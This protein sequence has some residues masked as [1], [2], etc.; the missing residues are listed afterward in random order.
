MEQRIIRVFFFLVFIV[1]LFSGC[2][3]DKEEMIYK[4]SNLNNSSACDTTKVTYSSAISAMMSSYCNSCHGHSAPSGGIS[5]D[6]YNDLKAHISRVWGS[7][8]HYQGY[9]PMPQG[10]NMLS[11]CDLGKLKIWIDKGTPN[12]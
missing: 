11:T 2:Y 9:S 6:N 3:Y 7:V 1:F 4:Y 5:L 10:G 12:N 8:N